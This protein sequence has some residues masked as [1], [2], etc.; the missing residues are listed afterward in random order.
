[1]FL[2]L[3][4]VCCCRCR[5]CRR[6]LRCR[7]HY[8]VVI[9]LCCWWRS[10]PFPIQ[11]AKRTLGLLSFPHFGAHREF[12][13][14]ASCL[15]MWGFVRAVGPCFLIICCLASGCL[16]HV[17]NNLFDTTPLLPVPPAIQEMVHMCSGISHGICLLARPHFDG[18]AMGTSFG[19]CGAG[20]GRPWPPI[21][22]L[23]G[24]RSQP[25][26][27]PWK[28]SMLKHRMLGMFRRRGALFS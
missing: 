8:A 28:A 19:R 22:G 3:M 10:G 2:E 9:V 6:C 20:A 27:R 4:F 5:R 23:S 13:G 15:S 16:S 21:F 26:V 12:N 14:G 11:H 1:M 17:A 18:R 25:S 24:C 7:C